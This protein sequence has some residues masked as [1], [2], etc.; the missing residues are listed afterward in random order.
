MKEHQT[1]Y[2]SPYPSSPRMGADAKHDCAQRNRGAPH[3][4]L[5]DIACTSPRGTERSIL[6]FAV[7]GDFGR[8][9]AT[10]KVCILQLALVRT[11][12]C[13]YLL[14]AT[15]EEPVSSGDLGVEDLRAMN[16]KPIR[17]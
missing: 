15:L 6:L 8:K 12:D 14:F 5:H 13:G 1:S 7:V 2:S 3:G 10:L 4:Q 11:R 9:W 16:N 17:T